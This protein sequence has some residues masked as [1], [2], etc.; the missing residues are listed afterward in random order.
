M[1]QVG[2]HKKNVPTTEVP[3]EIILKL[4]I[5]HNSIEI[6]NYNAK[7]QPFTFAK[8]PENTNIPLEA[9]TIESMDTIIHSKQRIPI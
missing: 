6:K 5:D 8:I 9:S 3:S 7:N 2:F 1:L 4:K